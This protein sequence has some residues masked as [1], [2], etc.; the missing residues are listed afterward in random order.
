HVPA[1]LELVVERHQRPLRFGG[2]LDRTKWIVVVAE[3]QPEHRHDRVAD[4]LLDRPAVRLEDRAHDRE[5]AVQDLAQRLR[6]EPLA[7]GRRALPVGG[8]DGDL[9]MDLA[10]GLVLAARCAAHA[11]QPGIDRVR[12]PTRATNLPV[13]R[14]K[15]TGGFSARAA[16]PR[17]DPGGSGA[18]ADLA[19]RPPSTEVAQVALI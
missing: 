17:P 1:L 14:P 18:L 6:V 15:S 13:H 9:A 16:A 2:G 11:A 12:R 3:R 19:L 5:V 8:D 4:D 7:E 10:A